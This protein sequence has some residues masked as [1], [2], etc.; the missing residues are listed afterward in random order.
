MFAKRAVLRLGQQDG[1]S[2]GG[3]ILLKGT[4]CRVSVQMTGAYLLFP[5]RAQATL[6]MRV[7]PFTLL[8][9]S[10]SGPALRSQ[11]PS[12]IL[13]S[14]RPHSRD[15][16]SRLAFAPGPI[17]SAVTKSIIIC[18]YCSVHGGVLKGDGG[19]CRAS[20]LVVQRRF[21][22]K[23]SSVQGNGFDEVERGEPPLIPGYRHDTRDRL[24]CHH[25]GPL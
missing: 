17:E 11:T 3:A 19:L 18:G 4:K 21:S 25:Q 9:S 8:I 6:D 12:R 13:E 5:S 24:E 7:R 23:P 10:V 20:M 22:A 14:P 16:D 2:Q 15:R 1:Y